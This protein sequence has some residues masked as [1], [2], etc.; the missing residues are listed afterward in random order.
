MKSGKVDAH[1]DSICT[2]YGQKR[3]AM[4]SKL[5]KFPQGVKYTKPDGGLFI[6]A[7]LPEGISALD[8]FKQSVDAG[9]AFVPGTHFYPEGG[10]ENTLRLN[11]SM[12][13]LEQIDKGMDILKSVIEKNL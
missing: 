1:I 12:A 6:W 13:S 9:V 4:L 11:F 5:A 2:D 3:D 10:H 8:V 7:S